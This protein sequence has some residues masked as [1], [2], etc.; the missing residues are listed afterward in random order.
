MSI[1][2]WDEHPTALIDLI[3]EALESGNQE[4]LRGIQCFSAATRWT[5]LQGMESLLNA[6]FEKSVEC[7]KE[8]MK[9]EKRLINEEARLMGLGLYDDMKARM[10]ALN[11]GKISFEEIRT[12]CQRLSMEKFF[13]NIDMLESSGF[14]ET[15]RSGR[16]EGATVWLHKRI[17][18]TVID[19]A[20]TRGHEDSIY[21][22]ALGKMIAHATQEK[23]IKTVKAIV[24]ILNR[25]KED[26]VPSEA[27]FNEYNALGI[28]IGKAYNFKKRDST[29]NVQIRAI[30]SD[31]GRHLQFNREMILANRRWREI[32]NVRLRSRGL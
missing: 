17:W 9:I 19:D 32:T 27:F 28:D 5:H 6:I 29:K 13:E 16:W 15:D 24:N 3:L 22:S 8:A 4:L 25:Y 30:V 26:L 23:T 20:L 2:H 18:S 14:I 21:C 12:V 1:T 31:D 7:K 10:E 11:E